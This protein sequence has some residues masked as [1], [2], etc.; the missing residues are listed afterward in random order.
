MAF[1]DG[2]VEDGKIYNWYFSRA[3]HDL[4]RWN[5]NNEPK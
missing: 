3:D 5:A 1:G 2:H 4:R